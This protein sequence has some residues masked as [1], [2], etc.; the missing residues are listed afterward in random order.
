MVKSMQNREKESFQEPK[1]GIG[2][3]F[4]NFWYHYKAPT[5]IASVFIFAIV[6]STVQIIT[7]EKYDYF[8]M[9]AGPRVVA[10]QDLVYMQRA[11]EALGDDLDGNGEVSVSFDDIVMLSPEERAAAA[12]HDA[13]VNPDAIRM[14]MTEYYQQIVGGD[15]IICFLSPYMYGM[16]R[17]ADGLVPLSE[18][19]SEIPVA[20]SEAAYD[21][22][23]LV[24]SK[25]AFGQ[26]FNGMDDLPEDTILCIRRL[27]TMAK[28]KGEKKTKE[29][30]ASSLELFKR[31][32][33]YEKE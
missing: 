16:V 29:Q 4:D 19:F 18:I 1:L 5:I 6:I 30:H 14:M 3:W 9:Y 2:A 23:G 17:E 33:L 28:L 31:L 7:R 26:S 13:M 27:S 12:E 11:V 25:T 15:A 20:V 8:M 21:E 22:C 24:L 10:I 32:A